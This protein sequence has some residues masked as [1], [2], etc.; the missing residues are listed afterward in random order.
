MILKNIRNYNAHFFYNEDFFIEKNEKEE[1]VQNI[2]RLLNDS[3]SKV[4]FFNEVNFFDKLIN[5]IRESK[6]EYC[7]ENQ[8]CKD[9][10]LK[11]AK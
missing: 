2:L 1:N 7:K 9:N 6:N 11:M 10:K 3:S 8:C 4:S 5:Q